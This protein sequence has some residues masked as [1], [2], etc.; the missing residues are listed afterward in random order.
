MKHIGLLIIATVIALANNAL[1]ATV[2]SVQ[3]GLWNDPQTWDAGIPDLEEDSVVIAHS[4]TIEDAI[5]VG[6]DARLTILAEGRIEEIHHQTL[7]CNPGARIYNFGEID[8]FKIV[9]KGTIYNSGVIKLENELIN[10]NGII[11]NDGLVHAK[12]ILTQSGML[13]GNGGQYLVENNLTTDPASIVTCTGDPIDICNPDGVTDPCHGPGLFLEGCVTICAQVLDLVVLSFEAKA[14]PNEHRIEIRWSTAHAESISH[15]AIERTYNV[16]KEWIQI[17]NVIP[18]QKSIDESTYYYL[19]TDPNPLNGTNM[20]R[21][22]C[23]T[24]EGLVLY[25]SISTAEMSM[26]S[27]ITVYPN[28]FYSM[29][30]ILG[31]LNSYDKLEVIGVTGQVLDEFDLS[32]M[33]SLQLG[34]LESGVYIIRLS[35]DQTTYSISTLKM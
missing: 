25:S 3:D 23:Y 15:F 9:N 20:Y 29:I 22:A 8:I 14:Y 6:E 13:S 7:E 12:N 32:T 10:H 34:Y 35:G 21:L 17:S 5:T 24:E 16:D 2:Y 26:T 18:V 27:N 1:A 4:I 28:P 30:E 19:F 33:Q 11:Y 31:D